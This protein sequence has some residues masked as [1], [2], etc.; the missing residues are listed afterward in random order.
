MKAMEYQMK[1]GRTALIRQAVES[2]A[3][4]FLAMAKEIAAET[5]N[6]C[7][8]PEE[9]GF[10]VEQEAAWIRSQNENG[11]LVQVVEV[12]GELVGNCLLHPQGG[13]KR[14]LHRCGI[15][16]ALK[17]SVWGNGLGTKLFE[18]AIIAA[19]ELGYEQMELEV[20][21]TNER[22]IRLYEKMGFRT[23]GTIPHAMKY[24]DGSYADHVNM[25]LDLR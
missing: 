14:V 10:T 8:T 11:G 12:D 22:G 15:G 16:I 7:S 2:D 4:S 9:Y 6:L 13:R 1:D 3:E 23:V 20:V 19:K 25:V 18:N 5:R 21:S 24:E 17:K